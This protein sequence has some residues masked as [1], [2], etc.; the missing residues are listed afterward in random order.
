MQKSPETIQQAEPPKR[1]ALMAGSFD[2]FTIGH[3]SIVERGLALFDEV[4]V[5]VGQHPDKPQ[6]DAGERADA[7]AAIYSDQPRVRVIVSRQLTADTAR[8]VGARFLLRGVRSVRDF[9]Y[10]R[11]MADVNRELGEGLETVLLTALP[12]LSAVSSSVV[13][14]IA[15][16]G[17]DVSQYLPQPSS[18]Q[19]T[20]ATDNG[21]R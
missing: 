18:A 14:D 9:E 11:D 5:A 6:T 2:P 16:Y 3:A 4:V 21:I 8:E 17:K 20:S 15:S 7:I 19:S 13:R 12:H 10:E 1:I